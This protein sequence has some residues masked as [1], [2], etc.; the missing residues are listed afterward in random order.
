MKNM[1]I[2]ILL[3]LCCVGLSY[4][5]DTEKNESHQQ[6]GDLPSYFYQPLEYNQKCIRF[7][8]QRIFNHK[9]YPQDFLALNFFHIRSALGLAQQSEQPRR[10][11][12]KVLHLFQPKLQNIYINPYAFLELIT[13]FPIIIGPFCNLEEEKQS[14]IAVLKQVVSQCLLE[15]FEQLKCNPE[16]TLTQLANDIYAL[17]K[18]DQRDCTIEQLQHGV[19]SFLVRGFSSIVWCSDDQQDTWLNIKEIADQ[20]ELCA[21]KNLIDSAMLE[22]LLWTL[23]QRYAYFIQ[24]SGHQLSQEFYDAV[25][26][27][28]SLNYHILWSLEVREA[29]I[30][31]KQEYLQAVLMEGEIALRI[32]AVGHHLPSIR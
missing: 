12:K 25:H 2:I 22:D 32:Y 31:M 26:H 11:M 9:R 16:Q 14:M 10:F 28:L 6:T 30:T 20:L 1:H 5:Q 29:Y 21:Q 18:D 19:Y 27:D 24:L 4:P 3:S 17:I 15:D 7:F 13:S 23:L 8:L